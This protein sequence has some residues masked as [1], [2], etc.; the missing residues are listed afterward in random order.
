[1]CCYV[2]IHFCP[3]SIPIPNQNPKKQNEKKTILNY[4]EQKESKTEIRNSEMI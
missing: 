1:M 2:F 4:K 3:S